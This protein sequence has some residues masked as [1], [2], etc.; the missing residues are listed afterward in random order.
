MWVLRLH[1]STDLHS[2]CRRFREFLS[3]L[4]RLGCSLHTLRRQVTSFPWKLF[5]FFLTGCPD[6]SRSDFPPATV[7]RG[8]H[9][10]RSAAEL[11]A[12]VPALHGRRDLNAASR[13]RGTGTEQR[14]SPQPPGGA[15]RVRGL[16][17][18][19]C[20]GS[21][22]GSG[23]RSKASSQPKHQKRPQSPAATLCRCRLRA[24]LSAL[25]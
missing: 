2:F 5:F 8:C 9:V 16:S 4:F 24:R 11:S 12:S 15:G 18:R 7:N 14:L 25:A 10:C 20:G 1:L 19:A 13:V 21:G 3:F 23:G 17:G 6:N 22:R